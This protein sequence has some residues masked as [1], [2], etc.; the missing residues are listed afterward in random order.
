MEAPPPILDDAGEKAQEQMAVGIVA[1]NVAAFI[2][3]AGDVPEGTRNF[4]S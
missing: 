4:E 1:I 3:A 2:A